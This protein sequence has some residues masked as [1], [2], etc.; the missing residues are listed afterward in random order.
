MSRSLI[1][2]LPTTGNIRLGDITS[3]KPEDFDLMFMVNLKAP[4]ALTELF[5]PELKQS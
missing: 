2:S 5:L 4:M 3:L 1:E